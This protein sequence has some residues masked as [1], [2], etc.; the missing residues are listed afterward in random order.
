MVG[1]REVLVADVADPLGHRADRVAA[2]GPVGV[3]VQVAA[4]RGPDRVPRV[5][6]RLDDVELEL[7]EVR[8]RLAGE[9]LGDDGRGGVADV[10]EVAQPA[11]FGQALQLLDGNVAD[12][13]GGAPER[14][15]AVAGLAA[16]LEQRR[17]AGERLGRLHAREGSLPSWPTIER[18][19]RPNG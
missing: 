12:R 15:H 13:D 14:L 4:Q 9:G 16:P 11:S 19:S 7:R 8:R 10:G 3:H 5:A 17:D 1:E 18:Q 2:V 6:S